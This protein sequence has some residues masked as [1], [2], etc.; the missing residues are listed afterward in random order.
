VASEQN[1]NKNLQT[2]QKKLSQVASRHHSVHARALSEK[3]SEL[4]RQFDS[5]RAYAQEPARTASRLSRKS[6][7]ASSSSRPRLAQPEVEN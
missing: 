4:E 2:L 6:D 5:R 7:L 1:K 3:Q